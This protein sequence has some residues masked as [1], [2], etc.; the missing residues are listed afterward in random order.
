M[1]HD[2][3]LYNDRFVS[4]REPVLPLG[5]V[6][7]FT[8]WGVFTTLRVY[9]G[10]PFAFERHW[11]RLAR[12]ARLLN[13]TMPPD[14]EVLRSRLIELARQ[15]CCPEAKMRLNIV[16][17][18][19]R[20]WESTGS[21][22]ESDVVAFTAEVDE[23]PRAAA[24]SLHADGRH[25]GSRFAGTKTLSWAHNLTLFERAMGSGFTDVLLLNELGEVSECTSAN[26]FVV[27]DGTTLTPFLASGALP[28]VTRQV[29][30]EEL[31]EPIEERTLRESDLYDADE[32]FITS[33]TREL[34]PVGR[35]GDRLLRG[36][37][38]ATERLRARF[39]AYVRKYV[40]S[41]RSGAA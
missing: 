28:G 19:P 8:G 13:V 7:L 26:V 1:L 27:R 20:L 11:D 34:V 35:I 16:R 9:E 10:I 5:H 39:H 15:N 32:V 38:P 21:A 18:L 25:T 29:M 33:S 41:A 36:P 23:P 40:R 30:L 3:V 31:G 2:L 22:P 6:G 17:S 12:D 4:S 14:R 24:L 37:W